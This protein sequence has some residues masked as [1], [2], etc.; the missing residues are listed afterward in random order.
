MIK[1]GQ[2]GRGNFG[3]KLL[4]NLSKIEG[5]EVS[6]VCN[7]QD[8]WWEQEKVDWVIVASPNEF[9]YEQSKYFLENETNV[10]C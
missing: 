2:I 5:I 4:F 3:K 8:F 1:V 10:L 6:W 7:S 9:H